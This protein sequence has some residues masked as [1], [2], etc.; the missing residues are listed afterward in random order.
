MELTYVSKSAT[1]LKQC[2]VGLNE[3]IRS[4]KTNI[5]SKQYYLESRTLWEQK[6]RWRSKINTESSLKKLRARNHWRGN[7]EAAGFYRLPLKNA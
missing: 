5:S 3:T 4:P 1:H 2:L 6:N 7:Y